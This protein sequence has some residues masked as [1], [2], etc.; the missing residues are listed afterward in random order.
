[1]FHLLQRTL[2]SKE[3]FISVRESS[4][5][6]IIPDQPQ[7][8]F[9]CDNFSLDA[10]K[11]FFGTISNTQHPRKTQ[12]DLPDSKKSDVAKFFKKKEHSTNK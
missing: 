5:P 2:F 3:F 10:Q 8:P 12:T 9:L 6:H 11:H 4:M 7:D 1:M